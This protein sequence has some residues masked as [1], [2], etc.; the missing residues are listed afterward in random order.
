MQLASNFFKKM[1]VC[2]NSSFLPA[3]CGDTMAER[4]AGGKQKKMMANVRRRFLILAG[5]WIGHVER[6]VAA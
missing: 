6:I 5:F 3:S 1:F 4:D 2:C